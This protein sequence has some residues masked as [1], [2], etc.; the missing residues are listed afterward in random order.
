MS[1]HTKDKETPARVYISLGSNLGDRKARIEAAI[2]WLGSHSEIRV[3]QYTPPVDTAPWGVENQPRF[4]NAVA[5]IKTYLEPHPL[6]NE[7]K[8][9]ERELGRI[10]RPAKWGPREIDLDIL[11]YDTR[12]VKTQDL[13]IPHAHLTQ[14]PFVLALLVQLDSGL[15]HPELKISLRELL[16]ALG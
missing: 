8:I 12:I 11:L 4:L 7:L 13:I 6:L 5:E 16:R 3:T 9:A 14:R 1:D 15:M 10:A 2:N